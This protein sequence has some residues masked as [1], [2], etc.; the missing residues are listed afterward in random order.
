MYSANP[1]YRLLIALV[2]AVVLMALDQRSK[3]VEPLRYGV[4]YL[5]APVHY[6]AHLPVDSARWLGRLS[7]TRSNLMES[8]ERLERQVLILEQK[9]QRLAVLQAENVRL[10]ELLNS[11]ANLD[12]SVLVAESRPAATWVMERST[13]ATALP[14]LSVVA[15][16]PRL[17]VPLGVA[18][19]KL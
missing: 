7:E 8:R 4:G 15:A 2:L 14:S 18:P 3:W 6:L 19:A 12:A 16:A 9:V 5:T 1:T 11:S 13:L 10:R 17:R